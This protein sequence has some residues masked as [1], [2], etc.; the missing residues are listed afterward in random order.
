MA[1]YEGVVLAFLF[2]CL[3]VKLD[4]ISEANEDCSVLYPQN[5]HEDDQELQHI[6]MKGQKSSEVYFLEERRKRCENYLPR[7]SYFP[8]KEC[9]LM[10][11]FDH[12]DE[13]FCRRN[14]LSEELTCFR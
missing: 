5:N 4:E 2:V 7:F 12:V 8:P 1:L 3:I 11:W 6:L 13:T 10:E 9:V 14:V